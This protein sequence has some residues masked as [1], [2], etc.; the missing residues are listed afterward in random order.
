VRKNAAIRSSVQYTAGPDEKSQVFLD[1]IVF[2]LPII[3]IWLMRQTHVPFSVYLEPSRIGRDL[4]FNELSG[5][6]T[7]AIPRTVNQ[8]PA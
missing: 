3:T 8:T 7:I 6:L 4:A 2:R 1:T 5:T